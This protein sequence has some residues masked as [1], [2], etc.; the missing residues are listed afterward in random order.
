MEEKVNN[1]F[2]CYIFVYIFKVVFANI[3][4]DISTKKNSKNCQNIKMMLSKQIRFNAFA[5]K[6]EFRIVTSKKKPNTCLN[7]FLTVLSN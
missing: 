1:I 5:I 6:N 4:V 3:T 2:H 7:I